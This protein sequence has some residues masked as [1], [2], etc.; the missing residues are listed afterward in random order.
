MFG[1]KINQAENQLAFIE[2]LRLIADGVI[3]PGEAVRAYHAVLAKLS[4]VPNRSLEDDLTLQTNVM[5]YVGTGRTVSVPTA[6][7][8]S[9]AVS[10]TRPGPV[11]EAPNFA[12]MTGEQRLAYHRAR[13]NRS[14]GE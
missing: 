9:Q 14:L 5:A 2:F 6:S 10:P 7:S 13:L 3:E 11:D 8:T 4:I 1:R 12:G